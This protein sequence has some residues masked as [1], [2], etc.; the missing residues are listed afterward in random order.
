LT[1]TAQFS[2]ER[3]EVIPV[4]AVPFIIEEDAGA[5]QDATNLNLIPVLH[6]SKLK[7]ES[8]GLVNG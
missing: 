3:I 2:D 6:G 1:S 5:F 4:F 8:K 7:T